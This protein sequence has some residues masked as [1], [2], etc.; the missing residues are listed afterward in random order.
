[1]SLP[2]WLQDALPLHREGNRV[3]YTGIDLAVLGVYVLV[4]LPLRI[5]ETSRAANLIGQSVQG[6]H[7]TQLYASYFIF[8]ILF[9]ALFQ[10]TCRVSRRLRA[11]RDAKHHQL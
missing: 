11:R 3:K 4:H 2:R 1:M 5:R 7:P 8:F 10:L 6:G 9:F